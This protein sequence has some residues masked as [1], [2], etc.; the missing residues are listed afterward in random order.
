[1]ACYCPNMDPVTPVLWRRLLCRSPDD[2][3]V[4]L[5]G[6][7]LAPTA[8]ADGMFVL[9]RMA[10]TLDGFIALPDGESHWI[11]GPEDITHTHRLRALFDAVLVGAGT[12]AADDPQLTTR[13]VEGPSPVRVVVD[14]TGRLRDHYRVFQGG[15]ETLVLHGPDARPIDRVAQ[16]HTIRLPTG[17][18]GL[19]MNAILAALRARGLRRIFVEGGGITVSRFLAAGML[20]RL[21]VTV[22]PLVIG[23]G[24]PSFALPPITRLSD[25]RRLRWTVHG[26]G[27][28]ILLDIPLEREA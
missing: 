25:G 11:S 27:Q 9:G 15:P 19:D 16:A 26:M 3:D 21:H 4:P 14:P 10:Q 24:I 6:P 22:A 8:Q 2:A 1:M 20:D 17:P 12:V 23:A 28:D 5:F 13:L 7:L 18:F